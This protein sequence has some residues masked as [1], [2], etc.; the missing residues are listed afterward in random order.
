MIEQAEL[1]AEHCW[2][3]D[4]RVPRRPAMTEFRRRLRLHQ[5]RWREAQGHPIGSQPIEPKG[6]PARPVGSR[7]PLAYARE[8]GASFLTA[9]ARA[10]VK[11]RTSEIEP[12]QTLDHQRLWADLLWSPTLAFNL[13]GDIAADLNRADQAVHTW[14]PDT[15]G[16][17]VDVRFVHSPG[18]LDPAY[19][20]SLRAFD[21]A[22]VLDLGDETS[23]IV[24]VDTKYH[25]RTKAEIP[26]PRNLRRYLEVADKSR[27]FERGATDA[28]KGRS[29][30]AVMWLEHLLLLSMLQ[31]ESATWS[32]G[33]YVVVYPA[34]NA[35]VADMC[36]RYGELLADRSTFASMT[37]EELLAAKVLPARTTAAL[38]ARYLPS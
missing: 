24:G 26:K 6:K 33:R 35:D 15:P 25:D 4:D 18:R 11:A 23:G 3:A 27:A 28:V 21:A 34:D 12:H 29:D 1:E 9:G 2:E 8:T 30:L 19:I 5:A 37:L 7:L 20:N 17:V 31:H 14:W 36:S 22:F 38:R 10:A 16:T 13:F 32:W